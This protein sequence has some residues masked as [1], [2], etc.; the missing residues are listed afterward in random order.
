MSR[1]SGTYYKG[2]SK[3]IHKQK[4]TE[5]NARQKISEERDANR[6]AEFQRKLTEAGLIECQKCGG[7]HEPNIAHDSDVA[8]ALIKAI[9]GVEL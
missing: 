9:F 8:I 6:E 5:A 2:A 3:K 1:Y 4:Q 7:I